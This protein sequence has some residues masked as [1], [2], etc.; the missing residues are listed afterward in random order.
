MGREPTKRTTK[1]GKKANKDPNKPKKALSSFMFFANAKRPELRKE[2]PTAKITEIGKKL[3]QI[4]KTL[5]A[6]DKKVFHLKSHL[7]IPIISIAGY[8]IQT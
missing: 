4:W 8:H 2:D 5:S 3:G 7:A 1:K 6:E